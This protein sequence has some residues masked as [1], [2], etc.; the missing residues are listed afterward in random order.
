MQACVDRETA[1]GNYYA[2]RHPHAPRQIAARRRTVCFLSSTHRARERMTP[3]WCEYRFWKGLL[4]TSR[5]VWSARRRTAGTAAF[6]AS[7]QREETNEVMSLSN[8]SRTRVSREPGSQFKSS[9][10]RQERANARRADPQERRSS[11]SFRCSFP[12]G[13]EDVEERVVSTALAQPFRVATIV[14]TDTAAN[15]DKAI[16]AGR[17]PTT[18]AK[19][20]H[21]STSPFRTWDSSFA[22]AIWQAR[23]AT[24]GGSRTSSPSP[25]PAEEL[26]RELPSLAPPDE[27]SSST[28]PTIPTREA[29]RGGAKTTEKISAICLLLVR[30][31]FSNFSRREERSSGPDPNGSLTSTACA[32]SP[33]FSIKLRVDSAA[34]AEVAGMLS[35]STE[36]SSAWN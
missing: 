15:S 28:L 25:P 34:S 3:L 5:R 30:L 10:A 29:R 21:A 24:N 8:L 18:A 23:C 4:E 11:P 14:S 22:H 31:P 9:K 26:L 33:T 17:A 27:A 13:E 12:E 7:P 19:H 36:S 1:S 35:S 2:S 16:F 32:A 6:S 20:A